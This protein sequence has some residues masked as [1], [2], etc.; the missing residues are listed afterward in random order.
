MHC[1]ILFLWVVIPEHFPLP[2][3][4]IDSEEREQIR[5]SEGQ[6]RRRQ[7]QGSWLKPLFLTNLLYYETKICTSSLQQPRFGAWVFVL[8]SSVRYGVTLLPLCPGTGVDH[9]ASGL[10]R[11]SSVIREEFL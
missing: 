9:K 2:A 7:E 3:T 8:V 4:N 10:W 5:D 6:W 1:G 11:C